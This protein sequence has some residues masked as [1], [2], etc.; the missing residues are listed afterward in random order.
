MPL[1]ER[2]GGHHVGVADE[3]QKGAGVASPGPEVGD[4]AAADRLDRESEPCKTPS[5]Q[6]LA[7]AVLG[8][9]RAAGDQLARKLERRGRLSGRHGELRRSRSGGAERGGS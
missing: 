4:L 6:F 2:A 8:G 7:T 5:E 1:V 3:A 9:D